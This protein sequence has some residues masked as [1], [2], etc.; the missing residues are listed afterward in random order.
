MSGLSFQR[1]HFLDGDRPARRCARDRLRVLSRDDPFV[2]LREGERCFDLQRTFQQ[3]L[4][5]EDRADLRSTVTV[6]E[7]T[8]E[9]GWVAAHVARTG[10]RYISYARPTAGTYVSLYIGE[11]SKGVSDGGGAV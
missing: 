2:G 7:G 11:G 9:I 5:R 10:K 4:A 3:S 8:E 1:V 6:L